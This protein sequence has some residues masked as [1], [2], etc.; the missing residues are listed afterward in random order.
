MQIF[1]CFKILKENFQRYATPFQN[2]QGEQEL[3]FI[4]HSLA[5]EWFQ[6]VPV[7]N[8]I[9]LPFSSDIVQL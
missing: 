8:F 3:I 7:L 6:D 5:Y 4:W 1:V 9:V 2:G